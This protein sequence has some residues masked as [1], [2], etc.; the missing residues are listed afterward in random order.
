MLLPRKRVKMKQVKMIRDLIRIQVATDR[1][2]SLQGY[3]K[4]IEG[5]KL[6]LKLNLE[7]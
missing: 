1:G 3:R 7:V 5:L 4:R 2:I 6:A